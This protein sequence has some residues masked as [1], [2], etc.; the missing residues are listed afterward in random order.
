M[1]DASQTRL[2]YIAEASY[3]STPATPTFKN[4]RFTGE[5]F[6]PAIQYVSSNEIRPD[7][8]V[9][10]LTLVGSEAAGGFDF[11]LSYGS[12]DDILE[13][14]MFA[15]WNTNVLKNGVTR[16]AFTIEKT[17]ETG[18]TD[19]YHRF[20]GC[21]AN[22]MSLNVQARQIVTGNFGFLAKGMTS[23]QAIISGATYTAANTNPVINAA[24]NFANLA[25]TGVTS[26]QIMALTLNVTNNLRQQPVVGQVDS[27]GIGTGRFVVT[28]SLDAYFENE[29]L[30]DLYLGDIASDLTFDLGGATENKY[31]FELPKI[32]FSSAEIV[33]GGNDQD[34][35][36]RMG[37]QAIY[38]A[39]DTATMIITRVP[40]A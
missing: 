24:N 16:K 1:A 37:F 6:N 8:N 15:A 30:L 23:G 31:S 33:A 13:S 34:V 19:Q 38:S 2:A 28:G 10:D 36:A 39:S 32:K 35:M 25:I 17:F 7:R 22:T 3:G 11:E 29:D 12:F 14:L 27:K 21:V 4:L 5:S 18:T 9:P 20:L 40:P 26:P